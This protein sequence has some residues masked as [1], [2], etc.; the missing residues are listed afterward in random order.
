MSFERMLSNNFS[1]EDVQRI[2]YV[3]CRQLDVPDMVIMPMS[4]EYALKNKCVGMYYEKSN[5]FSHVTKLLDESCLTVALH[6]L[7]HHLQ[8][9]MY[10]ENYDQENGAHCQTFG[11]ACGR[12]A[13][14]MRKAFGKKAFPYTPSI[15]RRIGHNNTKCDK[16][17]DTIK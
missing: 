17:W 12:I 5:G 3:V 2:I 1:E 15:L 4:H 13:T 7:G 10:Q 16:V 14:A 6:E 9:L 8:V 11:L